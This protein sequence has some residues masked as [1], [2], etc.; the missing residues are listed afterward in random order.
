MQ[1]Q[2]GLEEGWNLTLRWG[3]GLCAGGGAEPFYPVI[4]RPPPRF[5]LDFCLARSPAY[6]LSSELLQAELGI[7]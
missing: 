6:K 1:G 5:K 7:S 2:G 3:W 4:A